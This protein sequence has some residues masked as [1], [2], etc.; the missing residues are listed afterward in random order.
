M[1][2]CGQSEELGV[3]HGILR[4]VQE[5]FQGVAGHCE[6]LSCT[7]ST[8]DIATCCENKFFHCRLGGIFG[9]CIRGTPGAEWFSL[10]RGGSF[11]RPAASEG[12]GCSCRAS[13]EASLRRYQFLK[14]N[15]VFMLLFQ[16]DYIGPMC[17]S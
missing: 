8:R 11:V 7:G 3:G 4:Q 6:A 16:C 17:T 10:R 15:V 13:A 2:R 12:A 1:G 9:G 5:L 14:F